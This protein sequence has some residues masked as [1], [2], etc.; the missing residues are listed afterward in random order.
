MYSLLLQTCAKISKLVIPSQL[1]TATENHEF[2][3]IEFALQLCSQISGGH[4]VQ[5]FL[6][7]CTTNYLLCHIETLK[8]SV[9]SP[10]SKFQLLILPNTLD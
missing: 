7:H 2:L 1:N 3:M 9:F 8:S 4:L 6:V 10:K 5:K